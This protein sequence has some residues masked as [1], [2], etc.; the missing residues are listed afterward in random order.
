MI[1][2]HFFIFMLATAALSSAIT[3][4]VAKKT[5]LPSL[6]DVAPIK[7]PL[8]S[9]AQ[10]KQS[11][12]TYLQEDLTRRQE[13]MNAP[14][15]TSHFNIFDV[16]AFTKPG[17]PLYCVAIVEENTFV[18]QARAERLISKYYYTLQ[19]EDTLT[20]QTISAKEFEQAMMDL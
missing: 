20:F 4:T 17:V 9:T 3:Y 7:N 19:G 15:Q 6:T 13:K 14:G 5:D 11:C 12:S 16:V 1:R 18:N 8:M 2:A 10:I